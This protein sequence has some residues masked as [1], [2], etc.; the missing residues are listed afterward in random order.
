MQFCMVKP[1]VTMYLV[2]KKYDQRHEKNPVFCIRK[3]KG[4]DQLCGKRALFLLHR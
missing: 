4:Q 2:R 3:N 1:N